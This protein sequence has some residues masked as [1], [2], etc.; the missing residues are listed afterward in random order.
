MAPQ[1]TTKTQPADA[2]VNPGSIP[3]CPDLIPDDHCDVFQYK[4]ILNYPVTLPA[5][6]VQPRQLTVEVVL[7]FKF[8]RC[9][10]GLTLGDPAYSTTLLPGEK[11]RLQSTDRRSRF[12]FDSESKL[13]TRSEQI[14]EEQFYMT[15]LQNYVADGANSQSG[16]AF[17]SDSSNWNFHGDAHGSVG[18][19]LFGGSADASTNAS[20]S[21]NSKSVSDYLNEQRSHAQGAATQSV[22]ETRKAHSVS[23]GEVSSRTH[24]QGES[25]DQ[26]ES[27]SREF[28][29][30]NHCH[31]ITFIFYRLNKKQKITYELVEIE[32]RVLDPAAPVRRPNYTPIL[33]SSVAV[34]PQDLTATNKIFTNKE[35]LVAGTEQGGANA[36]GIPAGAQFLAQGFTQFQVATPIPADIRNA[37]LTQVNAQL[38]AEGLLD[39]KGNTSTGIKKQIFFESVFSLP[40]AGVIVKGCLDDCDICEPEVK[41]R[42]QLE[43]ELL[44]KQIDLLEK[45]QEYRCCPPAPVVAES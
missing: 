23:I 9:T 19:S 32:R 24:I 34:V 29:N 16:S 36:A 17:S 15:A 2:A 35:L 42:L 41:E 22:G 14:S 31:A 30:P 38:L 26:F 44:K 18:L 33:K 4:R 1:H 8:T 40:T 20:G 43:N 11:V 12:T 27:S 5:A 13:S 3:C 10:L 21:H 37:A 39:E 28:S 7:H 45:S 25:E 6:D